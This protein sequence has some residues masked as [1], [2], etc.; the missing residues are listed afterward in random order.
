M[1]EVDREQ[2]RREGA[3]ERERVR[4]RKYVN[5]VENI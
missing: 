4:E 2:E 1:K 5:M 3:G